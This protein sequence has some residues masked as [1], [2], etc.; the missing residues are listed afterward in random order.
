MN[1]KIDQ[2]FL[3]ITKEI[4]CC[5][6]AE[7]VEALVGMIVAISVGLLR[8]IH[9]QKFVEGFLTSAINDTENVISIEIKSTTVN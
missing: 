3:N 7:E 9:D 5:K 8:G 4:T 6:D 2:R 1:S